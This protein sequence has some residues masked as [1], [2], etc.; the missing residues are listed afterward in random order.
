MIYNKKQMQPLIDKYAINPE[1]NKLF[2]HICEIFDGQPN[3]QIWGVKMV[4]SKT[5]SIETLETI[6]DWIGKNQ[7]A[8][9]SLDKQNIVSYT[10]K[11]AIA[12]LMREMEGV[13]ILSIVKNNISHFNTTQRQLLTQELLEKEYTPLEAS[14]SKKLKHWADLFKKFNRLPLDR[15]NKF[16]SSCSALKT[17]EALISAIQTSYQKSYVWEKED[18]LAFI[19]NNTP[20]CEVVFN[21]GP[22][23]VVRV[24][25]FT[26]SKALCGNGRT[27][28]CLTRES[29]YFSQYAGSNNAEQYFYFDFNRKE[30]DAF[31]HIGFTITDGKNITYAQTCNNNDMRSGY[32]Q[33]NETLSIN[34]VFNKAKISM[35]IFMHLKPLLQ[36]QWTE[37]SILDFINNNSDKY[38]IA[39]EKDGRYVINVLN[40]QGLKTF[41]EHTLIRYDAF[42]IA[43]NTKTYVY[44]DTNVNYND[45]KSLMCLTYSKDQYGIFSLASIVDAYNSN[46]THSGYLAKVGISTDNFLNREAIDP[47]ILLHK[48]IDEKDEVNAIKLIEK[49][50]K[51]FD[52]NYEF[53]QRTPIIAALNNRMFKLFGA[54]VGHPKFNSSIRDGFGET[55]LQSLIYLY[56]S[57]EIT[58]TEDDK[59]SIEES[60]NVILNSKSY[61]YNLMDM[62]SDTALSVACE[63]NGLSWIIKRLVAKKNV[64][65]NIIN[66]FNCTPLGNA[67]RNKNVEALKILGQRPDIVVSEY[68][69]ELA[70]SFNIKLEDFI[71]PN[72]DIF[73]EE[74]HFEEENVTSELETVLSAL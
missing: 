30:A 8:V 63:Y 55:L 33:G 69:K 10:S 61:D 5:L 27:T 68:D 38:A 12:Q 2:I 53:L 45:E 6:H 35:S 50:G 62:N 13:D 59:K 9:K 17:T 16:Y 57:E 19:E 24:P 52:V 28:W 32:T 41:C 74:D 18:L 44:V 40:T 48:L 47:K 39:F 22:F 42:Q 3:Y 56:G 14:Q 60:I 23:V 34:D 7:N 58:I 73:K 64:N 46:I 72:E 43:P 65:I 71:K 25:S 49:E 51:S 15:R 37:E 36:Y 29:H 11:S 70:K 20:D 26:S 66:D 67:I 31:A 4:F 1:T 54:I 21:E